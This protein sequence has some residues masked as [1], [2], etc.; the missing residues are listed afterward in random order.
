MKLILNLLK[1]R[2]NW[3][4]TQLATVIYIESGGILKISED[5]GY[6]SKSVKLDKM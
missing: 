4:Y 2:N 5:I 1:T 6:Y 3:E